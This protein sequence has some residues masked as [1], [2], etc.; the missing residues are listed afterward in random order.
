M[1]C[2]AVIHH[3]PGHQSKGQCERTDVHSQHRYTV[4]GGDTYYW[5]GPESFSGFFD[6]SLEEEE[7]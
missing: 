5:H 3:G 6:E 4:P 1:N 2:T 7:E